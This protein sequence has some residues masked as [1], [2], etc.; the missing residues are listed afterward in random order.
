MPKYAA[1]VASGGSVKSSNATMATGVT[2]NRLRLVSATGRYVIA[3][4][5][6][7]SLS[8]T[9]V[10]V[11]GIIATKSNVQNI[12]KA[13]R[14]VMS[15][16]DSLVALKDGWDGPNSVAVSN[17]AFMNYTRFLDLLGPRLRIDAEPMATPS[18]GIR[19]EWER[20][21]YSYIAEIEGN[22]G[23]FLCRL[24]PTPDDD[25]EI[26]LPY[27]DLRALAQFFEVGP[28]VL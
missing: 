17:Q 16:L 20:G 1:L 19:M 18:G 5:L 22:G 6:Q 2:A 23:M 26:E 24:G 21:P 15:R 4:G 8:R 7:W 3:G 25:R 13:R 14:A 12:V 27:V 10:G 9:N 11:S 28:I